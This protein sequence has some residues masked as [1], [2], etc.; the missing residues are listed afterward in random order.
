MKFRQ[1]CGPRAMD[2]SP[3]AEYEARKDHVRWDLEY[4]GQE[5]RRQGE[6][7]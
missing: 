3:R 6:C 4:V 7:V 2:L 1:D 5:G